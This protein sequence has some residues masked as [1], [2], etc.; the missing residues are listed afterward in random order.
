MCRGVLDGIG[1][2][3]GYITLLQSWAWYKLPFLTPVTRAFIGYPPMA[4]WRHEIH[5]TGIGTK[6][7]ALLRMKIEINAKKGR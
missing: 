1:E 6:N 5:D 4:R 3:G 2:M 7:T